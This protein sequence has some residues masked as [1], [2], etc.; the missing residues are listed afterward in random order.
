MQ[1]EDTISIPLPNREPDVLAIIEAPDR[2]RGRMLM[3]I[4]KQGPWWRYPFTIAGQECTG[5]TELLATEA[6]R[7]AVE[8]SERTRR[9]FVKQARLAESRRD[10]AKEAGESI[11]LCEDVEWRAKPN[12]ER[13]RLRFA[14]LLASSG[15]ISFVSIGA[16]ESIER[17]QSPAVG[18]SMEV[19]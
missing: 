13:I 16:G 6:D 19:R 11:A 3:R 9:D 17:S 14:S 1:P 5:S 12:T 7:K 2:L 15:G 4:R 10:F 18:L 8:R